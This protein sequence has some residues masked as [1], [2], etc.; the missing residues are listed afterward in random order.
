ML[1]NAASVPVT[2]LLQV[3]RD[4]NPLRRFGHAS[5]FIG[6][7]APLNARALGQIARLTLEQLPHLPDPTLV[8]G[9]TESSL[10]LAWFLTLWQETPVDLRFTTRENRGDTPGRTFRE[11]HSHGPEHFLALSKG[12]KFAQILVIEDEL[13]T[14]ATMRNLIF[15]LRDVA[16]KIWVV[17]LCDLRSESMKTALESELKACGIEL[18][19]LDLSKVDGEPFDLQEKSV[20]HAPNHDCARVFNPFGRS[21]KS[22][23][24]ARFDLENHA[25]NGLDALYIIGECVDIALEWWECQPPETRPEVRQIT[26]SPWKTDG[27]T[28]I[29]RQDFSD[30]SVS[31]RY[32]LYNFAP[33]KAG[34]K[35]RAVWVGEKSTAA[36]GA[37]LSEFLAQNGVE[38]RS[39]LVDA[40]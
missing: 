11:P 6:K 32:F 36:I 30:P 7:L 27:E 17:T 26:R 28:V 21:Q 25:K 5:P 20:L 8:I 38:S 2:L 33:P 4:G 9:M 19:V 40:G 15:A 31:S 18:T 22:L 39:V 35:S 3:E 29:S 34:E 1:L 13:T 12:A 16:Q 37:Q 10:L 24:K 14:G 23:E